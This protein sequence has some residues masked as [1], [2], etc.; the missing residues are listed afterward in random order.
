MHRPYAVLVTGLLLVTGLVWTPDAFAARHQSARL[1]MHPQIAQ[2]GRSPASADRA[3]SAMTAVLRPVRSGR[4]VV[5]QRRSGGRWVD[6]ATRREDGHGVVEVTAPYRVAG[7]IATYRVTA[8]RHRD[9]DRISSAAVR[10]DRWGPADFSAQFSGTYP[11]PAL[12][13]DWTTRVQDYTDQRECAHTDPRAARVA[14]GTANLSVLADT[15]RSGKCTPSDFPGRFTWRLNGM[16]STQGTYAFK[17]GYAA[18]RMKFQPRAG[19]HASFWLQHGPALGDGGTG[20]AEID[21]IEWYGNRP[22]PDREMSCQIHTPAASY[23][24]GV[25]AYIRKPGRFGSHWAGRYHVFSVEWTPAAYTFRIDGKVVRRVTR[26][27]SDQ[28]EYLVLSL[29]SSDW[30]LNANPDAQRQTMHVDWVRVWDRHP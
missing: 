25:R 19:Q 27:V 30:E 13:P 2:P 22:N 8:R 1:I 23:P 21:T 6:V 20:G 24:S 17:Y 29:L 16:I 9:L 12:P 5:L 3:R 18:A 15:T 26:G 7:R 14:N 10:A 11:A 28:P 4:K